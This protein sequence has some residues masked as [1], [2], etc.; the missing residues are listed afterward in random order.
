MKAKVNLEPNNKFWHKFKQIT[1]QIAP[2]AIAIN[3]SRFLRWFISSTLARKPRKD[4]V[5][6]AAAIIDI[7]YVNL[8]RFFWAADS[9][10]REMLA[11]SNSDFLHNELRK[12]K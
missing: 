12:E 10:E 4:S 5:T 2:E 11:F 6:L 7:R 1:F 8:P 9:L 3:I